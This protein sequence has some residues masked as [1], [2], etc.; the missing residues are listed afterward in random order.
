MMDEMF[1][2]LKKESN[3]FAYINIKITF[4]SGQI[5]KGSFRINEKKEIHTSDSEI[6]FSIIKKLQEIIEIYNINEIIKINI[7]IIYD[8]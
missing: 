3:S 4:K 8:K 6:L 7:K 1:G 5:S 2:I